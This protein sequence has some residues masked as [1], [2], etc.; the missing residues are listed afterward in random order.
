MVLHGCRSKDNLSAFDEAFV[1]CALP[2]PPCPHHC[3]DLDPFW[4]NGETFADFSNRRVLTIFGKCMSMVHS[5][6]DGKTLGSRPRSKLPNRWSKQ[7]V[8]EHISLKEP[9]AD[10]SY[11]NPKKRIGFVMSDHSFSYSHMVFSRCHIATTRCLDLRFLHH[12]VT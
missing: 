10:C 2:T 9:P 12:R 3:G 8:S 1:D 4:T 6:S 5:P 7:D 11:W